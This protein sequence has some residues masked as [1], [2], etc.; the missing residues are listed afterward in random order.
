MQ[1]SIR[2]QVKDMPS[3]A[4]IDRA[5]MRATKRASTQLHANIRRGFVD[6]GYDPETGAPGAW[7]K[8]K[9]PESPGRAKDAAGVVRNINTSQRTLWDSGRLMDSINVTEPTATNDGYESSIGTSVEYAQ[10]HQQQGRLGD[11]LESAITGKRAA[12]LQALGFTKARKGGTV[13]LPARPFL[14]YPEKWQ[15]QITNI[16]VRELRA[17]IEGKDGE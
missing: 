2:I 11:V 8:R 9:T 14:I 1:L 17:A 6:G 10:Y 12:F 4:D 7:P 13:K 15:R 5:L 16:W 3:D